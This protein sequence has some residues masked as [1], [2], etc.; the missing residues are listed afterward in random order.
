MLQHD[1]CAASAPSCPKLKM[2]PVEVKAGGLAMVYKGG[3]VYPYFLTSL[4][5]IPFC[6]LC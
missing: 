6:C 5:D 3:H 1:G 4:F 2:H